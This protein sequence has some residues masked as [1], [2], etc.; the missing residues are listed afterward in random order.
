MNERKE[1]IERLRLDY[2]ASPMALALMKQAADMLEAD[3]PKSATSD[4][5]LANCPQSVRDLANKIKAEMAAP[6]EPVAFICHGHLYKWPS[7]DDF[8]GNQEDHILLY[9]AS[10]QRPLLT[11]AE[12]ETIAHR[13]AS[14]YT[15]RSDP[16]YHSYGFVRH[17]LIDFARKVR[18]EL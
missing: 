15:H 16:A 13:T 7:E 10:V 5:W 2:T 3:A 12:I 9:A 8:C 14:K 17:T 6:Q 11:D 18:G 1:L 4:E